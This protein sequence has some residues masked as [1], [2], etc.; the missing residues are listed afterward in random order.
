MK[1]MKNRS[2]S[3]YPLLK[4][5]LFSA[6]ALACVTALAQ[7]T[8]V[9]TEDPASALGLT[10]SFG[11]VTAVTPPGASV[12]IW[13]WTPPANVPFNAGPQE[14]WIEPGIL[15]TTQT[16]YNDVFAAF[17]P[18]GPPGLLILSDTNVPTGTRNVDGTLV[19]PWGVY[20][21]APLAVQFFDR[22][23]AP[24]R[25]VPDGSSTLT[26]L[27]GVLTLVGAVGRKLGR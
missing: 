25:T 21:G 27:G 2:S 12:Q 4:T 13:D 8:L 19:S 1:L 11:T 18:S 3:N 22:G 14:S 17:P 26:L 9:F 10:A 24:S 7:N 5:A 20:G 16:T 15:S 23:D 6:F